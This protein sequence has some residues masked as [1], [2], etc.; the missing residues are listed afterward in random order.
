MFQDLLKEL[1]FVKEVEQLILMKQRE[2]KVLDESNL[3]WSMEQKG[4][5]LKY[6]D[7]LQAASRDKT[8][9]GMYLFRAHQYLKTSDS[10]YFQT[11]MK[12]IRLPFTNTFDKDKDEKLDRYSH[13][14][15]DMSKRI[16]PLPK[17]GGR[18]NMLQNYD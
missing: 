12:S 18:S 16:V 14:K 5:A 9:D 2:I 8:Q 11:K 7:D 17:Q 15:Y 4:E 10:D 6:I 13:A 3:R 1:F